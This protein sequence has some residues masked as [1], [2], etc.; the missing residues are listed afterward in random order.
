MKEEN[1]KGSFRG[2]VPFFIFIGIYLGSGLILQSQGVE[3]A[4]YQMP[5]PIAAFAG[6]ITAFIL[7]KGTINE[8]LALLS[9]D[10]ATRIL[11]SCV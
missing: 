5:A 7:F 11:E 6:I 9:R 10:V 4:F 8:N 3:L 2:L 1:I